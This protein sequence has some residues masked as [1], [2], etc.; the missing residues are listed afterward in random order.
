[1]YA[2]I[3]STGLIPLSFVFYELF[4]TFSFFKNRFTQGPK[5]VLP[6][7]IKNILLVVC[8]VGLFASGLYPDALF[9]SLWLAPVF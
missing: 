5:F 7:S 2:I 6:E 8:L 1:M 9:F 3:I 4:N